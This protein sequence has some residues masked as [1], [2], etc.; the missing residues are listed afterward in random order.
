MISENY[1]IAC[2]LKIMD[3][4]CIFCGEKPESKNRE[5][6]IPQWLIRMTGDPNRTVYLGRKWTSSTLDK[7]E[8]SFSSFTFPACEKCNSDFSYLEARAKPIMETI[9]TRGPLDSHQWDI[10]LDWLDKVRIG[11]WLGMLYLNENHRA[12]LP[13]FHIGK[14]IGSK[15][16]MVIVYEIEGDG[17]D[18]V[19]WAA[20]ELPLFEY[21]PSCFTLTVNNFIFLN[22]SYDFLFA[23]RFGFPFPAKRIHRE[24]GGFWIEM[25]AGTERLH[26]PLVSKRFKTGGTQLFQPVIPYVHFRSECGEVADYSELYKVPYVKSRCMDFK[27]GRGLIYRRDCN[28]LVEYP[29][30]PVR[31]WIPKQKFARGEVQHQTSVLAGEF[32]EDIYRNHPSFDALSDNERERRETEIESA[33][34]LHKTIMDHFINQKDM[35]Y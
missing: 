29:D 26:F 15:D 24:D 27:T 33:I 3:K 19:G 25:T 31:D 5:H 16:R 2:L 7:R 4:F 6:V 35:Y 11:L 21:M 32:L 10:F 30:A 34:R 12:I 20:T 18:G 9:L 23:E 14:R 17:N 22:A 13:M 8:F 1:I 28:H